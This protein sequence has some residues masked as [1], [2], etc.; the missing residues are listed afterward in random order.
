MGRGKGWEGVSYRSAGSKSHLRCRQSLIVGACGGSDHDQIRNLNNGRW[1]DRGIECF[2]GV[3]H[4][5]HE[6]ANPPHPW[7]TLTQNPLG[8]IFCGYP[9]KIQVDGIWTVD[10]SRTL[11]FTLSAVQKISPL[12]A[13]ITLLF[14][15]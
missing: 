2:I 12:W 15:T 4:G 3:H 10:E 14:H 11:F 6:Y 7:I 9:A 5:Y 8:W 1:D 13:P